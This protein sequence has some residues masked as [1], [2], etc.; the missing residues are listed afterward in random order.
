MNHPCSLSGS[1]LIQ[2]HKFNISEEQ[3][4]EYSLTMALT[5]RAFEPS[6]AG[7]YVCTAKNSIGEVQ[8]NIQVYG[9]YSWGVRTKLNT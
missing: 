6:D 9:K 7:D 4:S 3:D 5:I 8:S 2:N 1:I